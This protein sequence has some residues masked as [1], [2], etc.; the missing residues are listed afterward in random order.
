MLQLLPLKPGM[1]RECPMEVLLQL[2]P[3]QLP[4]SQGDRVPLNLALVLD[5]SGSMSGEKLGLTKVA[6]RRALE[7]LNSEDHLSL[8]IFDDQVE[9]LY[10][11]PVQDKPR[12][13]KLIGAIEARNDTDLCGGWLRGAQDISRTHQIGRL[14]R[15]ILLTDG[16]ANRGVVDPR[17][18]CEKV[19]GHLT[20]GVQTTTLGFGR[21]Y[22]Q[23]LLSEMAK[24][25]GGN[26]AYIETPERLVEFFEEEM[27]SL[28]QAVGT[29]VQV[30][31]APATGGH[32]QW[33]VKPGLDREGQARLGNLVRG[34]PLAL[35]FR[36]A[37][38]PVGSQCDLN[39]TVSWSDLKSGKTVQQQA[40]LSLPVLPA[41]QWEQLP[42]HPEVQAQAARAQV[43][44]RRRGAMQFLEQG[45]YDLALQ[46]LGWALELPNLPE[47]EKPALVDLIH[48]VARRDTQAGLKKAA[49]YSHGHGHGHA[50]VSAHYTQEEGPGLENSSRNRPRLSMP[51]GDGPILHRE[52]EWPAGPWNRIEGMLRGHFFGERLVRGDKAPLGEGAALTAA[53]LRHQMAYV[54]EIQRLAADLH[55]TPLLHPTTSQQRFRRAYEKGDL[56][57][58]EVGSDSAGCAALRRVCPFLVV[59]RDNP[60]NDALMATLLTHRDNLA[61]CA[62]LGYLHLLRCLL[63]LAILPTR[64]FYLNTFCSALVGLEQTK[65]N[66]ETGRF[67]GWNGYLSEFLPMAIGF[68]RA[69]SLDLAQ[70]IKAWGSGPYLLEVLPTLLYTLE[71]HAQEPWP[72]LLNVSR[73]SSETD[74]LAMLTGAALGALH[75]SQPGWFLDPA[76]DKLLDEVKSL[77]Y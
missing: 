6:A 55:A 15:V 47:D 22:N 32:I 7:S 41:E 10:N 75:G 59:F 56:S 30:Q 45:Q 9:S 38:D 4:P 66:C 29:R 50:R 5:R 57:L 17:Q 36:W 21:D 71:L 60:L 16:Q 62:C 25:G 48:T 69:E 65:Y 28:I 46:W 74:T 19:A 44:L 72:A 23:Q 37:A 27:A 8:V 34:Q 70:A 20:G 61:L 43:E 76:L 35:V 13:E 58:L 73:Y 63:R 1:A 18:I 64:D 24:E 11:G 31:I 2:D 33:I 68:A 42:C 3:D 51:L 53:T 40:Q 26:H 52:W 39:L 14:S 54:F 77:N 49:M 67:K 12:I